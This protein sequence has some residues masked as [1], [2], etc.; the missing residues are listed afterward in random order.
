MWLE[1]RVQ[2]EG[3]AFVDDLG[4]VATGKDINQVVQTLQA[5][6]AE[7]IEWASRRDLQ[8]DTAKKEAALFTRRKGHKKHQ[9]LELTAKIKVWND[10]VRFNPEVTRWLGVSMDAHLTLKVHHNRCIE[11]ARGAEARLCSLTRMQDIVP[12]RVRAVQIAYVQAVVLYGS[13]LWWDP[14]EIGRRE[15]LQLPLNQQARSTLGALLTTPMGALMRESGL[16]PAPVV[17][18]QIGMRIFRDNGG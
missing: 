18:A 16:T 11:K 14:R 13:E 3:L 10:L 8:F 9:R 6:A 12:E 5:C 4:W 1:E 2:A 15:D 7:S 17:T